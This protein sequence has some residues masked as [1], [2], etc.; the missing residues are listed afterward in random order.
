VFGQDGRRGLGCWDEPSVAG[1]SAKLTGGLRKTLATVLACGLLVVAC[2]LPNVGLLDEDQVG[3][4]P[5][6]QARGEAI[7]DG[8]VPYR[9]F[10]VEYPPG[11]LPMFA[12]PAV[13]S[14][15][16]YATGFK[17][18]A[19]ALGVLLVVLVAVTLAGL[20]R[21][22][23]PLGLI[24]LAPAL[25]GPVFLVNF[26]VWPA[27]LTASALAFVAHGRFRLAHAALAAGVAAKLYPLVLL[28]LLFLHVRGRA[29]RREA[30]LGLAVFIAVLAVVFMP[31]LAIAPGGVRAS[32]EASVRR[33][34]QIETLG[35]SL[36]LAAHQ[37]GLYEPTVNSDYNS[38]N[39]G[40]SLPDA[41]VAVSSLALAATLV[42]V[43]VLFA[44]RAVSR[45]A[46]VLASAAA[47]CAVLAFGK[48]LSPQLLVWLVPL[49]PLVAGRRGVVASVLL[50]G[51]LLL[52]Q[53]W[54]P[55]RYG[56]VVRLEAEGWLV[57]ARNLVLVALLATL[58]LGLRLRSPPGGAAPA[59]TQP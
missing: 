22:L 9:D 56:A 23:A 50:A 25:L 28:P 38:Q 7:L 11:A 27:V 54:F 46:L 36:L 15:Q 24:A 37:L 33:P 44:R 35:A 1:S 18:L 6:Y 29:G 40:G 43:Y 59:P 49:V 45:D 26:D 16:G 48:I 20:G 2:A 8:Q 14:S 57:L 30:L 21:S 5:Q 52:T 32:F 42:A 13:G 4:T 58:A 47:V 53:S 12:L 55:T 51:A 34:L 10:Y 19:T 39:L 3:D 41:L 17:V 31:F